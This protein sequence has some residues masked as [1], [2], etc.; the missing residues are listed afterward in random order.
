MAAPEGNQNALG[1]NGGRPIERDRKEIA[2]QLLA[3]AKKE[4]SINLCGFCI[5][6][7]PPLSPEKLSIY[8]DEDVEFRQSFFI[9]KAMLGERRERLLNKNKIHLKAYDLN[10]RTYD[11]FLDEKKS[12][13]AKIESNTSTKTQTIIF[14]AD[15]GLGSGVN[16]QTEAVPA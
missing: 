6:L 11:Y 16:I 15:N 2:K 14:K 5:S 9:A 8:R 7:D 4:D 3:W 1:N 12:L 10:A 13:E